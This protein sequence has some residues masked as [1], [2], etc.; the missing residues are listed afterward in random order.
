M[1][2]HP[3]E[4]G[5][6]YHWEGIPEGEF[7]FWPKS[8]VFHA[9]GR[10]AISGILEVSSFS[11]ESGVLYLPSFFCLDV[12]AS[13][14]ELG[15]TVRIYEDHPLMSEPDLSS[16]CLGEGDAI[17]AVNYFGVRDGNFWAQWKRENK[18][19][20]LIEDHT[21]DPLSVW[22]NNSTADYCFS[23]LRKI[24]PVPD[25]AISWSPA[26]AAL[27]RKCDGKDWRGSA[28]KLAA[29]VLKKEYLGGHAIPKSE[30]RKLQVE[31]EGFYSVV[32]GEGVSPWSEALLQL[33]Y[34]AGWRRAR[35]RNV[36]LFLEL[37]P[38]AVHFQPLF[39]TWP[40]GHCPFNGLIIFDCRE[41]RDRARKKLAKANVF[42]P[43]HW[44][45]S[46]ATSRDSVD[47]SSRI[48]TIPLDQRY[49][50]EDVRRIL[51]ILVDD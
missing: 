9:L 32:K 50:S 23:S 47:I 1:S 39:T 43:V 46:G 14:Q 5:S 42:A 22:A 29:M 26:S 11:K 4:V 31:G 7:L 49:G 12:V 34:P 35:E 19:S 44:D 24:F 3:W 37:L 25:G 10:D 48:L 27:P 17:L 40:L 21:H 20:L 51:S 41:E 33:G 6:E 8:H 2:G 18:T 30:F 38:D 28:L 15:A 13:C 36:G 16:V 45:L